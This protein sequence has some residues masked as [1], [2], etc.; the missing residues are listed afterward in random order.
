MKAEIKCPKYGIEV[1]KPPLFIRDSGA[2][3]FAAGL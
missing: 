2:F 1:E 3:H